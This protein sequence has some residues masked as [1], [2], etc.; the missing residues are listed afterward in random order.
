MVNRRIRLLPIVV[1]LLF[2]LDTTRG[3]RAGGPAASASPAATPLREY[4][5]VVERPYLRVGLTVTVV[6]RQGRPV[7]GLERGDFRVLEDGEEHE[8]ADFGPEATRRDRP[9]SV[10]VLLDLSYSMGSQVKKVREAAQALLATLRPGDEIMVA[11]FNDELTILQ[12]FTGDPGEPEKSLKRIG[13]ASGGTAIFRSIESTL[14]D[15]R[16]RAGRKVI[17][18]VSDGLDNDIERGGS[19]F[20]SLYLQDLIR[21]CF[22]TGT[23]VYGVRPGMSTTSWLPFEGFVEETGGRLLYTG[24]DLEALFARLGEEFLSQYY[25]GYDVDP[26]Q[27]GKRRRRIKV[28]VRR[29]GLS[30]ATVRGFTAE[31][32]TVEALRRDLLDDHAQ[33]RADAVYELS[34][35]PADRSLPA[36]L[37]A[38]ADPDAGVRD[39]VARGLGRLGDEAG[40]RGLMALLGDPVPT[41]RAAAVDALVQYAGR[42]TPLLLEEVTRSTTAEPAGLRLESALLALGRVGDERALAPLS[43]ALRHGG[44]A[45]RAAAA[46]AL[47]DLGLSEGIPA[48]RAALADAAPEVREAAARSLVGIAGPAA[49]QVIEDYIARE[50]DPRL[51]DRARALLRR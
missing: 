35:L 37:G 21:L 32:D 3:S 10:A 14:R 45:A 48:L 50:T 20:Q 49:R 19:V 1:T 17:L 5:R 41:V 13:T 7:R 30:V 47:G 11:R 27:A 34:F 18:V 44:S 43:A 2:V 24:G 28:E 22:R 9:L 51:K 33:V 8:L 12:N 23:T 15:L 16:G 39:L 26:E 25:L 6:D 40:L 36:I 31:R 29:P 42:A 4:V 38:A 46:R